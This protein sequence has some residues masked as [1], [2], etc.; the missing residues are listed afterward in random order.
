MKIAIPRFGE[1]L[2]PCFEHTAMITIFTVQEGRIVHRLDFPLS[3]REPLDRVRLLRDQEVK[4]VICGGV[5]CAYENLLRASGI[6][7][8][9]WVTGNAV[10]LLEAFL[11]GRLTSRSDCRMRS[12]PAPEKPENLSGRSLH[13]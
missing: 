7:V 4:T 5:D 11:Q 6:E 1:D 10:E 8:I 2:A 12:S 13:E 3:S 9:S